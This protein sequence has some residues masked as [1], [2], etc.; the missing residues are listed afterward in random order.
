MVTQNLGKTNLITILSL[1]FSLAL[2]LLPLFLSGASGEGTATIQ[3]GDT[4]L[5]KALNFLRN[6]QGASGSISDFS[7]SCWAVMAIAAA[8]ENPHNWKGSSGKSIVD[9]L[10]ENRD[11]VDLKSPTDVARFVLAMTAAGEN[12]RNI[13]GTNYVEVLKGFF[14]DGQIGSV[15]QLN[16][17][18]WGVMALVSAGEDAN[19]P[20]IRGSVNFIKAH[21]NAD[22]GW[23]WSIGGASDVDD[24]AAAVMALTSAGEDYA[25]D[26]IAKALQYLKS[27]Q[28]PNGGFSSW[29]VVNSAS[30][31]WAIGAICGVG[32]NP[33]DWKKDGASVFDHLLT[34]QNAD[35]SFNWTKNTPANKALMTAYAIVALRCKQYPANGLPIYV[36]IE[37][38]QKTIWR[39]RVFVAAS[40]IID[41]TGQTHY[42]PKPTALGALDK[43]AEI[44]GFNYKVRQTSAGLYVYSI[45]GEEA[46]GELKWLYRV[47]YNMPNVGMAEFIWNTT[48][49]PNPPHRELLIYYGKL[50]S[51]PLKI[52]VDKTEVY[53][54]ENITVRVTYY[55]DTN[56]NWQPLEGA[57]VHFLYRQYTTN[58]TGYVTITVIYD[59]PIWAEKAGYVRS[60]IVEVKILTGGEGRS[61]ASGL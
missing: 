41:D 61:T 10:I 27:Q 19:S 23:G 52:W 1:T 35:G 16:D 20:V 32:Q 54:G 49:P 39:R 18:F 38:N 55:N 46:S 60:D 3:S 58:A 26:T 42:L 59:P 7:T 13:G 28:Q 11:I 57:T 47:N 4:P 15:S 43:A 12:P 2:L 9:Y 50:T 8:G 17:D 5:S 22:G 30:D 48:S 34:L 24:T 44:G 33:A 6:I 25:T 21:Q 45:A 37:G 51:P 29:G 56:G 53:V 40:T 31:S 14:S 36:R